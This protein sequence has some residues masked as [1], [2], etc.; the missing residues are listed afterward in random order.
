MAKRWNFISTFR[1]YFE[2][3]RYFDKIFDKSCFKVGTI[4]KS[5]FQKLFVRRTG[6]RKRSFFI[7]W[8]FYQITFICSNYATQWNQMLDICEVW[9]IAIKI[10]FSFDFA[11]NLKNRHFVVGGLNNLKISPNNCFGVSFQQKCIAKFSAI[12]GL[13]LVK[14]A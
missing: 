14:M 10:R 7:A 12:F 9:K 13:S 8:I 2:T 1:I 4:K 11:K 6:N 5:E 3:W